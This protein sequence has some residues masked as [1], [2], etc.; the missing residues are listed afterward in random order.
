MVQCIL[1][2]PKIAELRDTRN[3]FVLLSGK[4]EYKWKY[5]FFNDSLETGRSSLKQFII[6]TSHNTCTHLIFRSRGKFLPH[7][8][9]FFKVYILQ[10]I[11]VAFQRYSAD[12]IRSLCDPVQPPQGLVATRRLLGSQSGKEGGGG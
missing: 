11:E 9:A 12:E 4:R 7:I 10:F 6:Y 8:T 3:I 2:L 1:R 5:T